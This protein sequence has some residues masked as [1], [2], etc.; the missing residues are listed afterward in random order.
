MKTIIQ[1]LKLGNEEVSLFKE[2]ESRYV[3]ERRFKGEITIKCD[4]PLSMHRDASEYYHDI[5][6]A[7]I[8]DNEDTL[9]GTDGGPH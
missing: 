2:D 8:L 6:T 5:V 9:P 7:I 1:S 3:L 4:F